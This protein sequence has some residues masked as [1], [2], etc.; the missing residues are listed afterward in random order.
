[1]VPPVSE[2]ALRTSNAA[3]GGGWLALIG[4][5]AEVQTS[6]SPDQPQTLLNQ[7]VI[8]LGSALPDSSPW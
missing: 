7:L 4:T 8:G 1:M 3:F 2:L 6:A 5:Q